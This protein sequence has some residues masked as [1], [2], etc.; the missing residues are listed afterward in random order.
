MESEMT[1]IAE[2]EAARSLEQHAEEIAAAAATHLLEKQ[3][4][5]GE[6]LGDEA[7]GIWSGHLK[8]R[9]LELSA[10]M[11][12]GQIGLF[13]SRVTWSREAMTARDV[14]VDDLQ[15]SLD[16]LREII[17]PYLTGAAQ[18]VA[19]EYIN[20]AITAI[21]HERVAT[22]LS[23]LDPG[24]MPERL[25]LRYIQAVIA[26]NAIPGMAIVLD[27]V[28]DGLS[29]QDAMLKVLLPAQRE[30]GRLWHVNDIS[31]AEEHM[32]TMTTQRLMAVL[33]NRTMRAPD[34]G[35]TAVA[36]AVT[37]NIHDM[38]IRAIAYLLEFDGWR[39]IYLGPDVPKSDI[40]AAIESF[41]SDL[42]LLSLALSSQLPALQR[43][44]EEVRKRLGH[45]VKIMV[46]GN[47]LAGAS[48]LWKEL[49]ADGYA[50]NAESALIVAN[51][52][53]PIE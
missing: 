19:D 51:E 46:G 25:A 13:I 30:V 37:G 8:Q 22:G 39:T 40:P 11:T 6:R 43:T 15:A 18:Q 50:K 1:V 3:T 14:E 17:G 5:I 27:A 34:S 49:G 44:I 20:S 31:V 10:A 45:G 42:V 52:L 48:E 23:M 36:A 47:G 24:L 4:Q 9:V 2:P 28:D 29:A 35:R 53:V 41:E 7:L 12:A 33:A 26:G 16:S 21:G 32:V 38:G